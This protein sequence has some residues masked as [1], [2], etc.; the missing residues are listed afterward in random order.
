M[1]SLYLLSLLY[2]DL[3]VQNIHL[4][5]HYENWSFANASTNKLIFPDI[6]SWRFWL[7][8]LSF[9]FELDKCFWCKFRIWVYYI[10]KLI[11][12]IFSLF[13]FLNTT[14]FRSSPSYVFLGI[15]VPKI[16]KRFTGECPCRS[17]VLVK[18][19]SNFIEITLRHGCSPVNLLHIFWTTFPK[20]TSGGLSLAFVIKIRALAKKTQ[21]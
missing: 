3:R 5:R 6:Y 18:L 19:Q 17:V 16:Y 15:G 13:W 8:H 4:R 1:G 7:G 11:S 20:N 21:D 14:L 2:C 12:R 9:D 10:W